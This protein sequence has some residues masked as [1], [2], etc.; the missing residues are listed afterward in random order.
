MTRRKQ[1]FI[2]LACHI[3][4][5]SYLPLEYPLSSLERHLMHML[6]QKCPNTS[7]NPYW[8]VAAY[9]TNEYKSADWHLPLLSSRT[10]AADYSLQ[11]F[12]SLLR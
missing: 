11:R 5:Q 8:P 12:A 4:Q 9:F 2:L 7:A 1:R 3:D 6:H 10:Q